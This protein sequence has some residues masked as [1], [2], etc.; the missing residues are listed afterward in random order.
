MDR[1]HDPIRKQFEAVATVN[2]WDDQ[3]QAATI[4]I[5]LWGEALDIFRTIPQ[6]QVDGDTIVD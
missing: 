3:D 4:I 5:E 6:N 2:C 1:C